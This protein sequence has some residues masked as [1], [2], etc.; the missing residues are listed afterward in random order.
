MAIRVVNVVLVQVDSITG[1]VFTKDGS[2]LSKYEERRSPSDTTTRP[3]TFT[4]EHRILSSTDVGDGSAGNSEN[5]PTI[6]DY[7]VAE[8]GDGFSLV[9]MDQYII[10]TQT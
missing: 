6:K 10:V 3:R 9:Y 2:R 7:L 8:D 4:T 1:E 5:F